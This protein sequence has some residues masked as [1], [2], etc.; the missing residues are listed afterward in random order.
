M[1]WSGVIYFGRV[2]LEKLE[3]KKICMFSTWDDI[4]LHFLDPS[5]S[6]LL[7]LFYV[8]SLKKLRYQCF[9]IYP[10]VVNTQAYAKHKATIV[11]DEAFGT[12]N[13]S[14]SKFAKEKG[15]KSCP[16]EKCVWSHLYRRIT[17]DKNQK[18]SY[19]NWEN[20]TIQVLT[21]VWGIA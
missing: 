3:Y 14:N 12:V 8:L 5:S 15:W 4:K 10:M 6:L 1:G 18:L 16:I 21:P 11:L 2:V 7:G 20:T 9:V 19:K 17:V 13:I